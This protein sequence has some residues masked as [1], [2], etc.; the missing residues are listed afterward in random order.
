MMKQIV[1]S[2]TALAVTAGVAAWALAPSETGSI[3]ARDAL[4]RGFQEFADPETSIGELIDASAAVVEAD[5]VEVEEPRW[6]SDDGSDWTEEFD[7]APAGTYATV[8]I[9]MTA[10][11]IEVE[12]VLYSDSADGAPILA[13]GENLTVEFR[14]DPSTAMLDSQTSVAPTVRAGHLSAGD[15]RIFFLEWREFPTPQGVG[16]RVWRAST[17]WGFWGI[18]QNARVVFPAFPDHIYSLTTA[19]EKGAISNRPRRGVP[20][21][22][23]FD[24]LHALIAAEKNTPA[25]A[26]VASY[27]HWPWEP[28]YEQAIRRTQPSV[29][30]APTAPPG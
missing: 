19:A 28:A 21:A 26:T 25:Q 9:V 10:V 15:E 4:R 14:G 23:Q 2:A 12:D 8:P 18:D 27:D 29:E 5:V 16:P 20:V 22:I 3:S 1:A 6:N 30:P 13:P 17:S 11:K 7:A 24:R